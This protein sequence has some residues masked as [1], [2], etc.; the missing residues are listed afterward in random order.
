MGTHPA[1]VQGKLK[2][3]QTQPKEKTKANNQQKIKNK[4]YVQRTH[5][6]EMTIKNNK[7]ELKQ[8]NCHLSQIDSDG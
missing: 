8:K 7:E 1:K 5:G 3:K 6:Y 4:P 2:H